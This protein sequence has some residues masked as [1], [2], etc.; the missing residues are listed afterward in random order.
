MLQYIP[1]DKYMR[2]FELKRIEFK[3]FSGC[4]NTSFFLF[5]RIPPCDVNVA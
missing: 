4:N 2:V 1:V 5:G 3:L